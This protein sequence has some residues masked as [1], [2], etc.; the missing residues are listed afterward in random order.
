MS[1]ANTEVKPDKNRLIIIILLVIIVIGGLYFLSNKSKTSAEPAAISGEVDFNG[2]TPADASDPE[3]GKIILK[4]REH[5][6]E[7]AYTDTNVPLSF[8]DESAWTWHEAETGK[9]YDLVAEVYYKDTLIKKSQRAVATAPATDVILIFNI[10]KDDVPDQVKPTSAP[11]ETPA[12]TP[13]PELVAISGTYTINGFIPTGSTIRAFGRRAGDSTLKFEELRRDV[14]AKRT[15]T[16]TYNE[17]YA[18]VTYEYQAELYTASGQFIGQSKYITVTAPAA[19][20]NVVINSTAQAPVQKATVTGNIKV[21]G[22]VEQNSTVLLLQRKH[23]TTDYTPINRYPANKSIDFK[24]TEAVAGTTYELTA[25]LQVN[26]QNTATGNVATVAAPASSVQ[27]EVDTNFNLPAPNQTPSVSCGD[28]DGTNHFNARISLPQV[29]Q[30]KKYHAEVG[31]SAG[32]NNTFNGQVKPNESAIVYIPA[33]S[34][35]FSRYAYTA[36]NDCNMSDSTNW[37][38]WSPTLGFKCPQ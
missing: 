22:P 16:F 7:T 35:Y 8:E 11:N 31:T 18:G 25:A 9:T 2:I 12:P 32:A 5:N 36:C 28:R 34:P 1:E 6:T 20:E 14:P 21:N 10:T 13:T 30:A 15:D 23:G 3:L 29:E 38:G 33:D 19:N 37:S 17:A 4:A 26:E 24:W 27:L